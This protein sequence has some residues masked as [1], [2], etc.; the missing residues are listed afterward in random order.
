MP[1]L[2]SLSL[3]NMKKTG[4]RIRIFFCETLEKAIETCIKPIFGI[5]R[6]LFHTIKAEEN[7]DDPT[8]SPPPPARAAPAPRVLSDAD[9]PAVAA[10]EDSNLPVPQ[11]KV[12][13]NGEI[14]LDE[15]STLLETTAAK[16]AKEDLTN[17][18]V[19]IENSSRY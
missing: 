4:F 5:L 1:G 17:S 14:I 13:P 7:A 8:S 10:E 16:K 2:A 18:P 15:S 19:V 12:G 9:D 3:I 11:V 6:K